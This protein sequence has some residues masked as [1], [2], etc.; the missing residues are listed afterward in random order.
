M[1]NVFSRFCNHRVVLALN[2]SFGAVLISVITL[3]AME[4]FA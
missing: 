1:I 3:F 4:G 2:I